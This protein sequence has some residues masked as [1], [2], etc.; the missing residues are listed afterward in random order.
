MSAP[1]GFEP[2]V[3][4]YAKDVTLQMAFVDTLLDAYVVTDYHLVAPPCRCGVV[5]YQKERRTRWRND[6]TGM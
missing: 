2:K 5:T 3:R 6:L 4:I 1:V